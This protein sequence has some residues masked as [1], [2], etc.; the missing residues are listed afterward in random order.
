MMTYESIFVSPN[1]A[2]SYNLGQ[3]KSFINSISDNYMIFGA[4][5]MK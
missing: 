1:K 4:E 2:I 5:M 3:N